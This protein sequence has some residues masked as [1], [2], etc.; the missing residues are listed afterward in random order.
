MA[1]RFSCPVTGTA[2]MIMSRTETP[3]RMSESAARVDVPAGQ[4]LEVSTLFSHAEGDLEL[5]L[6]DDDCSTVIQCQL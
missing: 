4:A 6:Y 3:R 1:I 5:Q 2:S